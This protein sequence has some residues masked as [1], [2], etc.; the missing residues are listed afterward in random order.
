MSND[1]NGYSAALRS[2]LML[3]RDP[4]G[5]IHFMN[6]PGYGSSIDFEE[7]D[8][9]RPIYRGTDGGSVKVSE[10]QKAATF[11]PSLLPETARDA[12]F[13]ISSFF[14]AGTHQKKSIRRLNACWIDCD[15]GAE[16][17]G[18]LTY[19]EAVAML[20][21]LERRKIW[22]KISCLV[23]SGD[24]AW[25]VWSLK[26]PPEDHRPDRGVWG[27][28][29]LNQV[30][31]TQVN[32]ALAMAVLRNHPELRPDLGAIDGS[33]HI[34][35]D[36]SLSSK[37]GEAVEFLWRTD[38]EL[39]LPTYT[40]AEMAEALGIELEK[41]RTYK[42]TAKTGQRPKSPGG[43]VARFERYI[44]EFQLIVAHRGKL[45]RGEPS[46]EQAIRLYAYLLAMT[47]HQ[48]KEI[49]A[50]ARNSAAI[51]C[52]PQLENHRADG[53]A[54]AGYEYAR[55][56]KDPKDSAK[57]RRNAEMAE[58]LGVSTEEADRLDLKKLR[59]DFNSAAP[60]P[61][62][63]R[64]EK[65]RAALAAI[66]G[67][68][69]SEKPDKWT[70]NDAWHRLKKLGHDCGRGTVPNDLKALGIETPAA[71]RLRRCQTIDGRQGQISDL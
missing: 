15:C 66:T 4:D 34:R 48:L 5:F 71:K 64:R 33:R 30:H 38:A 2:A 55:R 27:G 39:N 28:H 6:R 46:R 9:Y 36:G 67:K 11:H 65:R 1:K 25:A 32:R 17:G 23:F 29:W 53:M 41:P 52:E 42:A 16:S 63:L 40:L 62:K 7:K 56:V 18:D 47:G 69:D 60:A 57:P 31:H 19:P 50:A 44:G 3:H 12:V 20:L 10:L 70:I 14:R 8:A 45:R 35:I 21:D 68:L 61:G 59:P 13:S 43:H 54:R 49:E 37:T 24:G 51:H 26:G 22:P 58:A